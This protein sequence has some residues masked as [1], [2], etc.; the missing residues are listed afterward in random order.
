MALRSV[1]FALAEACLNHKPL[2]L[3]TLVVIDWS[4]ERLISILTLHRFCL[5]PW[6]AQL[7]EMQRLHYEIWPEIPLPALNGRTPIDAVKYPD[8]R[9]IV[10]ALLSQFE[11]MT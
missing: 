10:E 6:R 9:E 3:K 5:M 2:N 7:A 1:N 4:R 11:G 8:G